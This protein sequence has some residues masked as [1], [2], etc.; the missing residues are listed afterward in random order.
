MMT[1]EQLQ[2]WSVLAEAATPGPWKSGWNWQDT[3][4][5]GK[6]AWGEGPVHVGEKLSQVAPQAI[7]D[8]AFIAAAREAVP[9]LVAEVRRLRAELAAAQAVAWEWRT[10]AGDE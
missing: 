1:D 6:S 10:Q 2:E 5:D 8:A 7:A 3:I 4:S 9:A